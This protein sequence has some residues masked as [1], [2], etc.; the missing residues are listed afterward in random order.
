VPFDLSSGVDDCVLAGVNPAF[1]TRIFEP[2]GRTFG[3]ALT[4]PLHDFDPLAA[5]P[6][7]EYADAINFSGPAFRAGDAAA[8]KP[9]RK[10]I[11]LSEMARV[12]HMKILRTRNA[13]DDTKLE[14]AG[15][16]PVQGVLSCDP[17]RSTGGRCRAA[18]NHINLPQR[19]DD[20]VP[21]R[22]RL[23]YQLT[24]CCPIRG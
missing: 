12:R 5:F 6:S 20:L 21:T 23:V 16:M 3:S 9:A 13:H 10:R 24:S 7:I 8:V 4:V 2:S 15:Q 11:A 19:R 22:N 18:A 17:R 1:L 14:A